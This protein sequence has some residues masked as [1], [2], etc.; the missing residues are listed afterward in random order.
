MVLHYCIF[1]TQITMES[2]KTSS[3]NI[4]SDYMEIV[5]MQVFLSECPPGLASHLAYTFISLDISI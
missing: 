2:Y 4:S 1:I 3:E 5:S